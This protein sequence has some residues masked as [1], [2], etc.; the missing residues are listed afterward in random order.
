AEDLPKA[1]HHLSTL[2]GIRGAVIVSTCN[3]TEV[4][5]DVESYHAGFQ[6]LR[7][8]LAESRELPVEELGEPLDARYEEDA[9]KHLFAVASGIDSMVVGEPQ[10]LSQVREALRQAEDERAASPLVA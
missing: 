9:V 6:A 5:A 7:G 4:V 1:Y 8:F 3:R 2:E 10:I